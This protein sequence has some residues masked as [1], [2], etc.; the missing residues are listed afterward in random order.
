MN[1]CLVHFL[2]EQYLVCYWFSVCEPGLIF[3]A[4]GDVCP[5]FGDNQR[6]ARVFRVCNAH[7]QISNIGTCAFL[8]YEYF[9][10]SSGIHI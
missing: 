5:F 7:M 8:S 4:A 10:N 2:I 1:F 6:Q 3:S 9:Y